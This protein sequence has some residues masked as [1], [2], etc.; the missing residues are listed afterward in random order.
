[1]SVHS[2]DYTV[3]KCLSVRLSVT[4]RYCVETAKRTMKLFSP[5]GIQQ[6]HHSGFCTKS[7]GNIPT[8]PPYRG[9]ECRL[10]MKNRDFTPL[11]RFIAEVIQDRAV[12]GYYGMPIGTHM[13][14]IEWCY[15]Q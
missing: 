3:A 5:S 10:G 11:S 14:S 1:M 9:V 15:F 7:Y 6:P 13:R 2:E 4:R 8:A 12:H